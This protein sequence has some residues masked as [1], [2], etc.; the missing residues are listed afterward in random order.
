[1]SIRVLLVYVAFQNNQTY[2]AEILCINKDKV[3]DCCKGKCYLGK[4]LQNN[5]DTDDQQNDNNKVRTIDVHDLVD[6]CSVFYVDANQKYSSSYNIALDDIT[7]HKTYPPP[8]V[9]TFLS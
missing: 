9:I 7:I 3:D 6:C 4:Q 2:I 8:E 1:M 5:T